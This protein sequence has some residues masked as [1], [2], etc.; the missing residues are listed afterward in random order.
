MSAKLDSRHAIN[1]ISFKIDGY[2]IPGV[3]F[4]DA[5]KELI[6]HLHEEIENIDALTWDQFSIAKKQGFR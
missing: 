2:M 1:N 4:A 3:C 6:D 5:K